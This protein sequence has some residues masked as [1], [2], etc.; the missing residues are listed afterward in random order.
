MPVVP[1]HLLA[2]WRE[3]IHPA[4]SREQVA[5]AFALVTG[6]AALAV[7]GVLAVS[8][9]DA[10]LPRP[11]WL[12]EVGFIA[13]AGGLPLFLLG[14]IVALPTRAW[15]V[16]L[17]GLGTGSALGGVA[18]FSLW[19]PNQ[20]YLTVQAPNGYAIGLYMVGVALLAATAAAELATY[21]VQRA[22]A[23]T[24]TSGEARREVTDAEI[25]KDLDW[26]SQQGWSWGGT[27]EGE[28][29]ATIRLKDDVGP[30]SFKGRGKRY[31]LEQEGAETTE[32]GVQALHA[33]RGTK[34]PTT[35]AD[36]DD[37][38]AYLKQL[39]ARKAEQ[40]R[41]ERDSWSWKLLHPI[42]WLRG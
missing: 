10:L 9:G 25:M 5:I 35:D 36:V 3:R 30:L 14:L 7:M 21:F 4:A 32:A 22:Q 39:Q 34:K 1:Q 41:A 31:K 20:W 24:G 40:Q 12:R 17:S 18:L 16:A 13:A 28:V 11:S 26:A 19:Y 2:Y 8:L 29:D 23:T 38:V 27:R 42:Q 6:G 15:L 37:Q 33:L